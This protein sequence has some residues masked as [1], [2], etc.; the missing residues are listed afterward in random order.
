[1]QPI[2]RFFHAG[3][4]VAFWVPENFESNV[5]LLIHT[6]STQLTLGGLVMKRI[7]LLCTAVVLAVTLVWLVGCTK[8]DNTTVAPTPRD[9]SRIGTG[10]AN[11]TGVTGGSGPT[12]TKSTNAGTTLS[13]A[14][15]PPTANCYNY[16]QWSCA[17]SMDKQSLS[18]CRNA[19]DVATATVSVTKGAQA[20]GFSGTLCVTNGG[21]I[22]TTGLKVGVFVESG[23]GASGGFS[24]TGCSQIGLESQPPTLA[25]GETY[26][27]TYSVNCAINPALSYRI[28]TDG[29]V[30]IT[31]HSG[32]ACI[33]A[34]NACG[35]N[36]K[37][38][39]AHGC[40]PSNSC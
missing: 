29:Y 5:N 12:G 1:M 16:Y 26:C 4:Y 3:A 9:Q 35:P 30:T 19:C 8:D 21:D 2:F 32:P 24:P 6:Q 37:T 22:A 34:G 38:V 25:A 28:N 27:Y 17:K 7:V 11:P 33:G 13:E 15:V 14:F 39:S 10:P 18:I 23:S 40:P 31:N 36:E 20:S